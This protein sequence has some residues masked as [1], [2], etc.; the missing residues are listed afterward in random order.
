GPPGGAR[1]RVFFLDI[2][3]R[4]QVASTLQKGDLRVEHPFIRS[5]NAVRLGRLLLAAFFVLALPW[6]ST[7]ASFITFESGPVRP[8][9]MTPDGSKLLV[10]NTPDN[11][12][13]LFTI[14]PS[15]LTPAGSVPVGMEPVAVAV[16]NNGE[17]WVVNQLS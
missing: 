2:G 17:A 7:A 6:R 5:I 9:A 4:Q 14:G 11:R 8:L 16:L 10:A 1:R 3:A 15:G 13:E 12:L